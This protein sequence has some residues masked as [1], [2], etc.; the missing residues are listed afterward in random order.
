MFET[1]IVCIA[2]M[3][4][5]IFAI[6]SGE[7]G[8]NFRLGVLTWRDLSQQIRELL[9]DASSGLRCNQPRGERAKEKKWTET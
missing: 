1:I 6:F 2:L 7:F 5:S 8:S 9:L 4:F 3:S